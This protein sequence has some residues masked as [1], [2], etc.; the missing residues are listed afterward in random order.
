[1]TYQ[2][3][4]NTHQKQIQED[5]NDHQRSSHEI[6]YDVSQILLEEVVPEDVDTTDADYLA[7]LTTITFD[8][9]INKPKVTIDKECVYT[10]DQRV[11]EMRKTEI[12]VE[13][14]IFKKAVINA[15]DNQLNFTLLLIYTSTIKD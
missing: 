1:M 2:Q 3:E 11:N 10:R 13:W 8:E 6:D 7:H 14:E 9:S 12:G 5:E 15:I 4:K